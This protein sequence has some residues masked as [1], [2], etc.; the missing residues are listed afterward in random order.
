MVADTQHWR[1]NQCLVQA[2]DAPGWETWAAAKR[3]RQE[4]IERRCGTVDKNHSGKK[5]PNSGMS[6]SHRGGG[7]KLYACSNK[8]CPNQSHYT[9]SCPNLAG[10]NPPPKLAVTAQS[11]PEPSRTHQNVHTQTLNPT[12][13]EAEGKEP[14]AKVF[15]EGTREWRNAEGELHRDNDLP[16]VI[17]LNGQEEWYRHGKLHRDGDMPAIVHSDGSQEWYQ[18]GELHRD[19]DLPAVI[20]PSGSQ[21]WYQHG[22]LHRDGDMPAIV[23]PNNYEMWYQH[24]TLHRNGDMPAAIYANGT[25]E[26]WWC[27]Q[28]HRENDQPAIIYASG[29]KFWWQNGKLHRMSGPA[30][31]DPSGYQEWWVEDKES[32]KLEL[33]EQASLPVQTVEGKNRLV[34][35]CLHD[36]PVVAAIAAH[37]PDCPEEGV[38]AYYLKHT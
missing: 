18:H 26:W 29:S 13:S 22:M 36:D 23:S 14:S 16:A 4:R 2:G 6:S 20:R 7:K 35:L 24:G 30:L 19:N 3:K 21:K 10:K 17:Y 31:T 12:G 34:L 38:A 5:N 32:K 28:Y 1:A 37:N 9:P 25:Q 27:G 15:W 8:K 33:C 11:C